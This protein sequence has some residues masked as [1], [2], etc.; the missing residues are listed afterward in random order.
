MLYLNLQY[1]NAY[2]LLWNLNT[3]QALKVAQI[4]DT[5]YVSIRQWH[6]HDGI[7]GKIRPVKKIYNTAYASKFGFYGKVM[8]W[9]R[10][11]LLF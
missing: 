1:S 3:K 6:Q 7:E 2:I 10:Y 11:L 5:I 9:Y 4:V 8:T